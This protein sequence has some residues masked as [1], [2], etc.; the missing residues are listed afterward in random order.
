[1][2]ELIPENY[3]DVSLAFWAWTEESYQSVL[4]A[5]QLACD[6]KDTSASHALATNLSI[7]QV[8]GPYVLI[9]F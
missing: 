9:Y 6:I 1:V 8:H 7:L 2:Q 3:F 5:E 4:Q